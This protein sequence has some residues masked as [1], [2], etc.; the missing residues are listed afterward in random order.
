MFLLRKSRYINLDNLDLQGQV[1]RVYIFMNIIRY[2]E[3]A[4]SVSRLKDDDRVYRHGAVGIRN[5][6]VIVAACNGNPKEPEPK[7]HAE[8]RILRKLGCGKT[9]FVVRTLANG[10]WA[11]SKPCIHCESS[12]R[13]RGIERVYYSVGDGEFLSEDYR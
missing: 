5:D 2:L 1:Y 11:N 7:H 3:L 4:A 12:M 9:V 13:A 10:A 8:A 6:G